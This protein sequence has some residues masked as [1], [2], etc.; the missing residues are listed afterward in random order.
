MIGSEHRVLVEGPDRKEGFLSAKTEGR[1]IVRFPSTDASL[2]G[3]FTKVKITS[4]A[5]LSVE[6]ELAAALAPSRTA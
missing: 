3:S 5:S 2:I 4:A 6:G 1:I